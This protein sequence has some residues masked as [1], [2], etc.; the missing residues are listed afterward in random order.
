M[1][2]LWWSALLLLVWTGEALLGF[3]EHLAALLQP[4]EVVPQARAL[5]RDAARCGHLEEGRAGGRAGGWLGVR[6]AWAA[7][8]RGR[9]ARE[10]AC[11][12]VVVVV[13]G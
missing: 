6:T 7:G 10:R 11:V 12:V 2:V 1:R 9:S 8:E 3:G 4:R 5:V 13:V